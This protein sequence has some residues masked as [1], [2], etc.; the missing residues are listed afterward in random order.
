MT[1]RHM[2][3][4]WA[5]MF[6]SVAGPTATTAATLHVGA[7]QTYA[8]IQA[9]VNASSPGDEIIIHDGT[10]VENV[11]V[12]HALSIVSQDFLDNGEN[13]GAILNAGFNYMSGL[14]ITAANVS[15]EGLSFMG[16]VT[17]GFAIYASNADNSRF[18]NNRFGWT[19]DDHANSSAINLYQSHTCV[20]EDNL[21][22]RAWDYGIYIDQSPRT[23]VRGNTFQDVLGGRAVAL[24]GWYDIGGSNCHSNTIELNQFVNCRMGVTINGYCTNN[25]IRDNNFQDGFRGVVFM[26]AHYN[27]IVNNEFVTGGINIMLDGAFY[28]MVVHN[29]INGDGTGIWIGFTLPYNGD[30]NTI[31]MNDIWNH[32]GQ[33]IYIALGA[34]DNRIAANNFQGNATDVESRGTDWNT[35]T[36]VAYSYGSKHRNMLGNYYDSY[37]GTDTDGDGVGD[38]DLPFMAGDTLYGPVEYYP[39]VATPDN[40]EIE[41]WYLC[42]DTTMYYRDMSHPTEDLAVDPYAQHIWVSDEVANGSVD[43]PEATWTGCLTFFTALAADEFTVEIGSS[44]DG[45]DFTASG[46]QASIGGAAINAFETSA[47]AVSVPDGHYLAVRLTNNGGSPNTLN[48]GGVSCYVSSTGEGDPD[49]PGS[50]SAVREVSAMRPTLRQNYPN[51]FNPGTTIA[52][53]VPQRTFATVRVYDVGGHY[54]ATLLSRSVPAG[55]SEVQWDGRDDRGS[56]VASGIYFY[57]LRAG[58]EL[59][60]KKMVLLR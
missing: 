17:P 36:P 57:R 58:Q 40:F 35:A 45:T 41:A 47:A 60:T 2:H 11:T 48:M 34:D 18:A 54:V 12:S 26:G 7:G 3:V 10:Y 53:T 6:L 22:G 46:A 51:P 24:S 4:L 23:M 13:D 37:T 44:S 29:R 49:W 19:D 50:G 21:V 25:V 14:T 32:A 20:I 30:F 33:G 42:P 59:I 55:A 16:A 8:T 1:T 56:V 9:A 28:N 5:G 15:V 39:L 43:Y 38:T 31:I 52:F 27:A